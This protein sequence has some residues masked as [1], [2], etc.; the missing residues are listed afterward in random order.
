MILFSS[1]QTE[2]Y[3]Q[4]N[5][6]FLNVKNVFQKILKPPQHEVKEHC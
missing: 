5:T 6:D 4:L 1:S 3:P 2:A